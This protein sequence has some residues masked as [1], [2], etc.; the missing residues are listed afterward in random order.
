VW[1]YLQK[2]KCGRKTSHNTF[3]H[4]FDA[5]FPLNMQ[6]IR[7]TRRERISEGTRISRKHKKELYIYWRDSTNP[8]ITGHYKKLQDHG[9]NYRSKVATAL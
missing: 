7:K 1:I 4:I 2:C 9:K 5:I 6:K 8:Q 3:L